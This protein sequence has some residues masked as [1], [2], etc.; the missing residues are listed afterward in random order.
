[1]QILV[2]GDSED[3]RELTEAA[4]LSAGRSEVFSVGSALEALELL[5]L[6]LNPDEIPKVDLILLDI[7]MPEI[8]AVEAC[9][10]IRSDP[11]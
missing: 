6:G 5:D 1:M 3:S 2:V 9:R 11:R 10:R 8:D 4:L 7:V